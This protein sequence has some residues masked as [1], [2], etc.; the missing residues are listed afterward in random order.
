MPLTARIIGM[1]DL[2]TSLSVTS[3]KYL[4]PED[5]V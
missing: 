1:A 2:V 5:F 4:S 3:W